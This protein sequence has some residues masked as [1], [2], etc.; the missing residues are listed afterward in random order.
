MQVSVFG[1]RFV[2]YS[3]K[4]GAEHGPTHDVGTPGRADADW[5]RFAKLPW[6]V[7]AEA[8]PQTGVEEVYRGPSWA[9]GA[10]RPLGIAPERLLDGE[11]AA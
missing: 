11:L 5:V 4:T 9:G 6:L 10:R 3:V 7:K 1:I 8:M 2:W